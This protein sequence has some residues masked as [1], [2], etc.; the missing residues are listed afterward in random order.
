MVCVPGAARI[1]PIPPDCRC[2]SSFRPKPDSHES[3]LV[4]L[5]GQFGEPAFASPR[6]LLKEPDSILLSVLTFKTWV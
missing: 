6:A 1:V 4:M 5:L 2:P 3:Q